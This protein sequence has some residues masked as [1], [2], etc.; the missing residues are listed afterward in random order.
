V[1]AGDIATILGIVLAVALV[2]GP[3]LLRLASRLDRLHVR[4]DAAWSGLDAT[5]ARR[6]VVARAVA[7]L[8][9][10]PATGLRW[11]ADQA[12]AAQRGEREA[13]E[14]E[15]S[16][17]LGD[18]DIDRLPVALAEE[19]IDAQ[20][21]VVLARRVHNDAV[22]DTRALRRRRVV[23]WLKLAGTAPQPEYFEIAEPEL[24]EPA[25]PI[26]R[27]RSARIVLADPAG[28]VLLFRGHDPARPDMVWWFTPGGGAEHGEQLRTTAVR[29][30]RE[31]TGLSVAEVDLL[32]PAWVRRPTF[33][34]D[35]EVTHGEEWF[36]LARTEETEVD[37]S[38]FTLLERDT[39]DEH[40]W[41]TVPELRSTSEL[42]FPEQLAEILPALLTGRWDGR[43]QPIT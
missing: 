34:F 37:V 24:A 15:L 3:W 42:V 39:V 18:L 12:E 32:G 6:A 26:S 41:W 31:E 28:R 19:L 40:R 8:D 30:L 36:F 13:A 5:L 9:D 29:E 25:E 2:V 17:L 21:R 38:G 33:S 11:A 22:R 27:R 43:T 16:K 10:Q 7:A 23:R 20:H 14:N 1:N 4:T 35:G